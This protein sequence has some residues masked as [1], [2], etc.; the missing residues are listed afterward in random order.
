MGMK[1]SDIFFNLVKFSEI[2]EMQAQILLML[3]A[4]T[5]WALIKF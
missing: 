2:A 4:Y 3:L 5:K 1:M